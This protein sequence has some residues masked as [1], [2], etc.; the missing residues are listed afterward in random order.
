M[1][2]FRTRSN[3]KGH[4]HGQ[5]GA[6]QSGSA[7]I[8]STV[9][10]HQNVPGSVPRNFRGRST[11]NF[12]GQSPHPLSFDVTQNEWNHLS[13]AAIK[14]FMASEDL[15]AKEVAELLGCSDRTIDNYVEGKCS[16]AGLYHLRAL[17]VIPEYAAEVMRVAGLT[18]TDPEFERAQMDLVRAAWRVAD[19]REERAVQ[20]EREKSSGKTEE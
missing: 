16:P 11:G 5:D 20:R 18:E 9:S 4:A 3:G 14:A 2:G 17:T 7:A 6:H 1:I 12:R 10:R 19:L 13:G 8:G 15:T